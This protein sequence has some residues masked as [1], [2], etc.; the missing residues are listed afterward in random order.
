MAKKKSKT[1]KYKK[2][3]KKKNA[4]KAQNIKVSQ[5]KKTSN[6]KSKAEKKVE[7]QPKGGQLVDR[8]KVNYNVVLKKAKKDDKPKITR[9]HINLK[10]DALKNNQT[11]T[12]DKNDSS[13]LGL[14]KRFINFC[15][16]NVHIVFNAILIIVF[17]VLLF[18]LF[19]C[20]FL[21][22]KVII[23]IAVLVL[24]LIVVAISYNKYTSGKI[25]T[26]ILCTCMGGVI[27]HMQYTYGFLY[28]LNNV[29]YEY[30]TYY[31]VSFDNST[32]K[33]IYSINNKKIGLLDENTTSIKRILDMK[34]DANFQIYEDV[35]QLF[36]DFFDQKFRAVIV[37]ENQYAYL[38]NKIESNSQDVKILYEFKAN[39][40]K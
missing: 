19:S 17:I 27:Y 12:R 14:L 7:L 39:S 37:N 20:G 36:K 16:N 6:V 23:Y 33:N 21:S 22:T 40:H 5:E 25:L 15:E 3:L 13:L 2:N 11:H 4:K 18:G 29:A 32:N 31:L 24:F 8:D 34:V 26:I 30:K 38:K 28:T 10:Q 35:N 1:Q 9:K